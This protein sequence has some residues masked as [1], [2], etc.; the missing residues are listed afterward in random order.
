MATTFPESISR[1]PRT[2][3][4]RSFLQ[5]HKLRAWIAWR[6]DELVMIAGCYPYWGA[7]LLLVFADAKPNLVMFVPGIEPRYQLHQDVRVREY[8]WG[9]LQC[10]DP[11][12][13]LETG[14]LEELK[15]A[16][17]NRD[18][19][20]MLPSSARSSLPMQAGE[21]NPFP[22]TFAQQMGRVAITPSAECLK[23]F[24]ELYLHKTTVEIDAI[25]LANKIANLGLK[26]F[27]EKCVPGA[28]ESEVAA[29]VESEIHRQIGMDGIFHARA[30]ATV[31]SGPNSADAGRFNRSTARR[32]EEGDLA[33][34]EMGTCVNG[35]WSDLTRTVAV[36]QAAP[37]AAEILEAV[38][39]A[40]RAALQMVR[41][42]VSAEEVDG[43]ARKSLGERGFD[44]FFT[45]GSGH[46]VG[47]RYHDPGFALVPGEKA[48]LEA[49]MVITVEPGSYIP[50]RGAGARIEDNVL[51]TANGYEV[52]SRPN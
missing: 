11:F 26:T 18:E 8:P 39:A 43:A 14:I 51:V 31:Q 47:F 27:T 41:P 20:G 34:I 4:V 12:A 3:I 24:R 19:V 35:Y 17:I 25:R 2:M 23:D 44:K 30:W 7:S 29:A 32:M 6:P 52:L 22:E 45:H 21:Q 28:S 5:R 13:V 42:G 38:G 50:E 9:D 10:S 40:Q 46:H 1:L 48:K 49:G 36:G 15:K 37:N 16:G 33:L